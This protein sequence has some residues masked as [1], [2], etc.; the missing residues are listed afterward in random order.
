VHNKP[1]APRRAFTS[2]II[3]L[4]THQ[5]LHILVIDDDLVTLQLM[6]NLLSSRFAITLCSSIEHAVEDYLHTKPDLVFLDVDLGDRHF[7]GFDVAHTIAIHDDAAN[8]VM[9]TGGDSPGNIARATR[10]GASGFMAKP[11][12]ASR[13]LHFVQ[14][15]E[16]SKLNRE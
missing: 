7:N 2:E 14:E 1:S 13:I 9:I 5:S 16:R 12:S 10:A 11:L 4:P 8:I 3:P 6:D 15:C